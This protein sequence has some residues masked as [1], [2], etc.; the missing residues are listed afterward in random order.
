MATDVPEPLNRQVE[1]AIRTRRERRAL[2]VLAPVAFGAA[3]GVGGLLVATALNLSDRWAV[4]LVGAFAGTIGP[5]LVAR[6][7]SRNPAWGGADDGRAHD[8][9][10]PSV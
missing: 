6:I 4:S 10:R 5:A 9:S 7:V 1:R 3:F 2:R 8:G